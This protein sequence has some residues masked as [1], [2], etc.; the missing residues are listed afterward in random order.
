M[1]KIRRLS[2]KLGRKK[3]TTPGAHPGSFS[4]PSDALVPKALCFIY[5][6]DSFQ[7]ID[8]TQFDQ[9]KNAYQELGEKTLWLHVSGFGDK[10]F[11]ENLASLFQL[12]R[13]E[14]EDVFNVYQRP[15]VDEYEGHLFL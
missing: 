6:N 11:Y 3:T 9:L 15:K 2:V 5:D 14:L 7:E 12:H 13:L 1:A 8:V 10:S 4:I